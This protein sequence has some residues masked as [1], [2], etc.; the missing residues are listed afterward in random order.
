MSDQSD[1][2]PEADHSGQIRVIVY[3][4]GFNLFYGMR[5][6][7]LRHCYWLDVAKLATQFTQPNQS[8]VSTKYFTSIISGAPNGA[9]HWV[10]KRAGEKRK[11][12]SD[13]LE[14]LKSTPSLE[15]NFGK[16]LP[17]KMECHGCKYIWTTHEE[18][19]TDVNIAT[20]MLTDAFQDRFDRAILVTGDSDLVPPIKSIRTLFPQKQ[21][22]VAFPPKRHSHDLKS[23]ASG[24]F[25][26]NETTLQNSQFPDE[27]LLRSGRRLK[28]PPQ[29]T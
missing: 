2:A 27:V 5:D 10:A 22:I 12:Q 9:Q 1:S 28:R 24:S 3:L 6:S 15:I 17:S 16:Y 8:L 29:W 4:D 20:H 7:K 23:A 11:R 14:A 13:Y 21:I 18:K 26:I 25:F 19:M